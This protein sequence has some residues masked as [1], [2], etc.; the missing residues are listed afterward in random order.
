M[1]TLAVREWECEW[2]S[3]HDRGAMP[4]DSPAAEPGSPGES[5]D[6]VYMQALLQLHRG[7]VESARSLAN[8]ATSKAAMGRTAGSFTELMAAAVVE[9]I[10]ELPDFDDE[11]VIWAGRITDSALQARRLAWAATARAVNACGLLTVGQREHALREI[12]AA[13]VELAEEES[14]QRFTDPPG[15]P[16]GTGAAHN[17]L[18][19]ALH[20][21]RCYEEGAHHFERASEISISRYGPDLAEQIVIDL[22]NRVALHLHWAL[23]EESLGNHDRARKVA[24]RGAERLEDFRVRSTSGQQKS[25][26]T[27]ASVLSIGLQTL[28]EP[29]AITPEHLDQLEAYVIDSGQG[30]YLASPI[31]I[32]QARVARILGNWQV[33]I[34]AAETSDWLL[35]RR[36]PFAVEATLREAAL[37]APHRYEGFNPAQWR[38]QRDT[39]RAAL[40]EMLA[41]AGCSPFPSSD[42]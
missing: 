33:A 16:H 17:N 42:C 14:W 11:S 3:M 27:A 2:I 5:S 32:T 37:A 10:T 13:E 12:V 24:E 4:P 9:L 20:L 29:D 25:W 38:I 22:F 34:G 39:E 35:G 1:V 6:A 41:A 28:L 36:D 18:G 7:K 21:M 26:V 15:K 23:D 8:A 30:T 19:C 31:L 40:Y